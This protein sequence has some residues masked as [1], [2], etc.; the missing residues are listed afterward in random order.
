MDNSRDYQ[1]SQFSLE[2]QFLE[3]VMERGKLKH[4]RIAVADYELQIKLSKQAL[5]SLVEQSPTLVLR[6]WD[7]I[8]ISGEKK[9]DQQTGELKLKA[10][11]LKKDV[12]CLPESEAS[13]PS[14]PLPHPSAKVLSVSPKAKILV[15]QKS[16]C[17]K[18]GGKRQLQELEAALRAHGLQDRVMIEPTGCMKH[19]SSAPNMVLKPGNKR[20]SGMKPEA[21]AALLEN[22]THPSPKT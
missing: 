6:P 12:A 10:Y 20:L 4:L 22:L 18:K 14:C 9:L 2:G 15:C 3:F 5:A 8:Q 1:R 16:G 13:Y 21:I 11:H 17:L 19:C 7:S